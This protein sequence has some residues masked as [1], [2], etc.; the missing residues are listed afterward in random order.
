MEDPVGFRKYLVDVLDS[1]QVDGSV[2]ADYFITMLVEGCETQA[3]VEWIQGI[4]SDL[5]EEKCASL[6]QMIVERYYSKSMSQ[7]S[8][9]SPFPSNSAAAVSSTIEIASADVNDVHLSLEG[10]PS[11]TCMLDNSSLLKDSALTTNFD[12][13][14]NKD[15]ADSSAV[16]VNSGNNLSGSLD[17]TTYS[18]DD[19]DLIDL[20]LLHSMESAFVVEERLSGLYPSITFACDLIFNL[21]GLLNYDVDAVT[22]IICRAYERSLS[23]KPCRHLINSS[24]RIVNCPYEHDLGTVPCRYW[25][26]FT[27][28]AVWKD[29][30]TASSSPSS[31]A[32][33]CPFLHDIPTE[34]IEAELALKL[35]AQG[36]SFAEDYPPLSEEFPSLPSKPTPAKA[37]SGAGQQSP[38]TSP[39]LKLTKS[40]AGNKHKGKQV[41]RLGAAGYKPDTVHSTSSKQTNP[42]QY[43]RIGH[44]KLSD[45]DVISGLT[46][47]AD[48]NNNELSTKMHQ[49]GIMWVETGKS[50]GDEYAALREKAHDAAI[51]RNKLL[52]NATRAYVA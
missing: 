37:K 38:Q 50:V 12:I 10:G 45:K 7:S 31:S 32:R 19:N 43:S 48:T 24:C 1:H 15:N 49:D 41:I 51:A 8:E 9:S 34:W 20:T 33:T 4:C 44:D 17:G 30:Q 25:L 6:G 42:Q 16:S 23:C 11:D 28:C 18:E 2:Y 5:T 26:L 47:F 3:L 21:L 46:W 35:S 40:S 13:G 22:N 52:D 29:Q 39:K 14:D 36:S 27:G